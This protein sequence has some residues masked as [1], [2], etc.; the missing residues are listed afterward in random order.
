MGTYNWITMSVIS[1]IEF[2]QIF[3]NACKGCLR[4][5]IHE[6]ANCE[7]CGKKY[8]DGSPN[9]IEYNGKKFGFICNWAVQTGEE[10][11]FYFG[12][13]FRNNEEKLLHNVSVEEIIGAEKNIKEYL[14][15]FGFSDVETK[16]YVSRHISY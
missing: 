16:V 1:N 9:V 3:P 5:Y 2:N 11:E 7:E 6:N 15:A 8:N 10:N 4:A 12:L 13:T 14:S